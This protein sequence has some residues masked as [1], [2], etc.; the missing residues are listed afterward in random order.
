MRITHE[1]VE[2]SA[3]GSPAAPPE[4]VFPTD[5]GEADGTDVV[6]QWK[7]SPDP[8]GDAIADYHFELSSHRD[9]RWPLSM[10]FAKLI[11]RTAD[12]G[13]P[14]FTLAAPGQLN[15]DR[16]YFWR[17]RAQ[18]SQGVWGPWSKTWSFHAARARGAVGCGG[19]NS[20]RSLGI[21]R[22][23]PNPKATTPVAYRVY[24][25]DEKGFSVS[26]EPYKVSTGISKDL[27]VEFP[28]NF[29]A[30]VRGTELPV[31]VRRWGTKGRTKLSTVWLRWTSRASEAVPR[32]TPPHPVRLSLASRRP[33]QRKERTSI[34][35]SLSS[36]RWAI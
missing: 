8:D 5:G 14:R 11:S 4:A 18:D 17:V 12:A 10:S 33:V 24:A 15:P 29:L 9:M 27:P 35:R 19:A 30:E 26:D 16:E 36:G 28:A 1:W 7:P 32:T 20:T 25:S 3:S 34:M 6:F 23:T 2:R 21:L 22:W 13:Q 31:V